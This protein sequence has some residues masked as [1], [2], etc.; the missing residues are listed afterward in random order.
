[1]KGLK[2]MTWVVLAAAAGLSVFL[3]GGRFEGQFAGLAMMVAFV[4]LVLVWGSVTI[5][6]LVPRMV[7]RIPILLLL[8]APYP[9]VIPPL[10][11]SGFHSAR[12]TLAHD[13]STGRGY[14]DGQVDRDLVA[15]IWACDWPNRRDQGTV[16][17]LDKIETLAG[18]TD[19]AKT[20][21]DGVSHMSFALYNGKDPRVMRVLLRHGKASPDTARWIMSEL[22]SEVPPDLSLLRAALDGGMDPNMRHNPYGSSDPDTRDRTTTPYWF[23]AAGWHE[24]W[25]EGLTMFLD[26]GARIDDADREGYTLLMWAIIWKRYNV[27]ELLLA[28][29][30]AEG[31]VAA[32]GA[33]LA[34][35]IA[36]FPPGNLQMLPPSVRALVDRHTPR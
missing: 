27:A 4:C 16:C 11:M 14:F 36:R 23:W 31:Q 22:G 12:N 19:T 21:R 17:D 20:G 18:L 29:G 1:M 30:A 7:I 10:F 13:P 9:F 35:L 2:P 15:A 28:R 6:A 34:S 32:D 24:G 26:A 3:L 5:Y 25:R 33:T 8:L